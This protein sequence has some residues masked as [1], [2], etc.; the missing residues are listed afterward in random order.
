MP[1]GWQVVKNNVIHAFS[2]AV[3]F[4]QQGA[5]LLC[6]SATKKLQIGE[7]IHLCVRHKNP[8]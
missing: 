5:P 7:T 2:R 3:A 1:A 8:L 4:V 6:F